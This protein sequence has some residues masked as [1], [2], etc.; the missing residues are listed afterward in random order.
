M[1]DV[2]RDTVKRVL[3]AA[4]GSMMIGGA[5][6]PPAHASSKSIQAVHTVLSGTNAPA[7]TKPIRPPPQTFVEF[8]FPTFAQY[9]QN[10]GW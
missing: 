2:K 6:S 1:S 3:L 10:L 7:D 5:L 4:M 9:L 8:G